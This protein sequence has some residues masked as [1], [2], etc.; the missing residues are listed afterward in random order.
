MEMTLREV[1]TLLKVSRRAIQGYEKS[2]LVSASRRNERGY[3]LYDEHA[4]KRIERIKMLQDFGFSIKEIKEIIDAPT[5]IFKNALE[6][7]VEKIKNERD[8][9]VRLIHRMTDL[10]KQL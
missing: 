5:E 10:I 3:L 6:I 7:Q 1:G 4:Q 9:T 8:E 2:G